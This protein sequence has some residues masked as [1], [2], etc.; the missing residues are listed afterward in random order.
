MWPCEVADKKR[1]MIEYIIY[2]RPVKCNKINTVFI[3]IIIIIIIY[4]LVLRKFHKD[5]QMRITKG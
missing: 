2:S 1:V 5:D 4:L 3:I